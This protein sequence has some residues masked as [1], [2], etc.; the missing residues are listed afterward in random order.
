MTQEGVSAW[1]EAKDEL[2]VQKKLHKL[3]WSDGLALAA[4]DHCEDTG[5]KGVVS[6][7][8]TDGSK[9]WDRMERYGDPQ[10]TMGENLSFGKSR[11]DE[12]MLGLFI[13]DGVEDRGHRTAIQHPSYNLV[14]IAYCPHNSQYEN[15][16]AIAYSSDFKIS[17]YGQSEIEKRFDERRSNSNVSGAPQVTPPQPVI[18]TGPTIVDTDPTIAEIEPGIGRGDDFG[19]DSENGDFDQPCMVIDEAYDDY[20]KEKD[21]YKKLISTRNKVVS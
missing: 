16:V 10:G 18:D 5:S 11:G 15:M 6:H 1:L 8:G 19:R 13:D 3:R 20:E 17:A 7:D 2:T 4:Q 9:V 21:K 12:Y 14:G